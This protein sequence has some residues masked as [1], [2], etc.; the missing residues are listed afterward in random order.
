MTGVTAPR[1]RPQS[2]ATSPAGRPP[3]A[4]SRPP[5]RPR[6]RRGRRIFAVVA[7]LSVVAALLV[8]RPWAD[9]QLR[10]AFFLPASSVPTGYHV[11]YAEG[12]PGAA[13]S[14]EELWVRRPFESVDQT[15]SGPPPGETLSVSTVSRLGH[16]ILRAGPTSQAALVNVPVMAAPADVRLDAVFA[17][18]A[19]D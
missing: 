1:R 12:V 7:G 3:N 5:H 14:T 2:A 15:L 19:H 9:D 8:I 13:K 16:Q 17:A 4:R 6:G 10:N 18:A 11:V